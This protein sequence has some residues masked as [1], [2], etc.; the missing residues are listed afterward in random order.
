MIFIEVLC[1]IIIG[2]ILGGVILHIHNKNNRYIRCRLHKKQEKDEQ[3]LSETIITVREKYVFPRWF[4]I[5]TTNGDL[6]WIE[7]L[8]LFG[9]PVIGKTYTITRYYDEEG[10]FQIIEL[11]DTP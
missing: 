4:L 6:Y 11:H 5:I 9:K 8:I 7:D 1:S 2:A 3:L 10:D